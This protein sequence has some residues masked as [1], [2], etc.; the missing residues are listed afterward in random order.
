MHEE[1]KK[2]LNDCHSSACGGHLSGYLTA[3]RIL[4]AAYFWPTIFKDCIIVVR[5][6]LLAR[7]MTE[8]PDY[9][10]HHRI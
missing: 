3:Q 1:A 8:K 7:Y 9:H 5:S 10:L 6:Y 4:R 2:A